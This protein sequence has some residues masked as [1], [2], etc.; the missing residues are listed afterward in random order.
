MKRMKGRKR[1]KLLLKVPS[2]MF[3]FPS[4]TY[5]MFICSPAS[6][7]W[8]VLMCAAGEDSGFHL[9]N[10]DIIKLLVSWKRNEIFPFSSFA[11]NHMRF[12]S[13]MGSLNVTAYSSSSHS[14]SNRSRSK[15]F[16]RKASSS[17]RD[18][19]GFNNLATALCS[20]W[21]FCL[22]KAADQILG[23]SL[24]LLATTLRKLAM[25]EI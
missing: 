24:T 3:S 22:W 15:E 11:N 8:N 20:H 1:L 16:L 18:V 2:K 10:R 14:F 21:W 17:K 4:L 6:C 9:S 7:A 13:I 23:M 25:K 5:F 12:L 19:Q